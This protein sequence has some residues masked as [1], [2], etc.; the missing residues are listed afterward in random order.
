MGHD[1]SP[2]AMPPPSAN[3]LR[4]PSLRRLAPT[5]AWGSMA[6][7][8]PHHRSAD[9]GAVG[10]PGQPRY[11]F[12]AALR[13]LHVTHHGTALIPAVRTGVSRMHATQV[14]RRAVRP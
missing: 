5:P 13:A 8:R 2:R 9:Q 14:G 4:G 1:A 7:S 11:D 12:G 6:A 10:P 3:L